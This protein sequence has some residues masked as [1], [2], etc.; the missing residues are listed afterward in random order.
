MFVNPNR[1]YVLQLIRRKILSLWALQGGESYNITQLK[2][3]KCEFNT[4]SGVFDL[5]AVDSTICGA[6]KVLNAEN[7]Q[8]LGEDLSFVAYKYIHHKFTLEELPESELRYICTLFIKMKD[9]LPSLDLALPQNPLPTDN[10]DGGNFTYG[11]QS[12]RHFRR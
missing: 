9:L 1:K 2:Q 11:Q 8:Y 7:K 3:E 12:L 4:S 6:I 10:R 5:M